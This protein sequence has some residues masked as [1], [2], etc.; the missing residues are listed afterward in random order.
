MTQGMEAFN[1]TFLRTQ[2]TMLW[3]TFLRQKVTF[4]Y[5]LWKSHM[6]TVPAL[7]A[8]FKVRFDWPFCCR[9]F[10]VITAEWNNNTHPRKIKKKTLSFFPVMSIYIFR[11]MVDKTCPKPSVESI[12]HTWCGDVGYYSVFQ[13]RSELPLN[14]LIAWNDLLTLF[15]CRHSVDAQKIPIKI[16][17]E[18][19]RE[20]HIL[21]T[22]HIGWYC[23]NIL[24]LK[25]L[26]E[27]FLF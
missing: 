12:G 15:L 22:E 17:T 23:S 14:I 3:I 6:P 10:C 24:W 1:Q 13:K 11:I 26:L 5:N 2:Q 7:R 21:T 16:S 4:M 8:P 25:S 27:R 18:Y 19:S 9:I 20:C